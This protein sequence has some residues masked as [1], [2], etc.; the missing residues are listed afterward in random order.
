MK[1]IFTCALLSYSFVTFAMEQKSILPVASGEYELFNTL[2]NQEEPISTEQA[3]ELKKLIER[4]KNSGRHRQT[5]KAL[6]V[7][8]LSELPKNETASTNLDL[9]TISEECTQRF[10]EKLKAKDSTEQIETTL[11]ILFPG[12]RL[13]APEPQST[14]EYNAWKETVE[15]RKMLETQRT[16]MLPH[17]QQTE[18]EALAV[19]AQIESLEQQLKNLRRNF[20]EKRNAHTDVIKQLS[21][22]ALA[23][24]ILDQREYYQL[25][26]LKE[27]IAEKKE[28]LTQLQPGLDQSIMSIDQHAALQVQQ[29]K[30]AEAIAQANLEY[31]TAVRDYKI[32]TNTYTTADALSWR[33]YGT[34][35]IPADLK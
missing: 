31:Y 18:Q 23:S 35:S 17:E 12:K 22:I 19:H 29:E 25:E 3:Q 9:A 21:M 11:G 2:A 32:A 13:S 20:S 1:R 30:S 7:H 10:E 14:E 6:A 33:M 5:I 34:V 26:N 16:A 24:T 8:T 15:R 28:A 27:A 4:K